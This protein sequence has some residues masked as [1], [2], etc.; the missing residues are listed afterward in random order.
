MF[1]TH[2]RFVMQ[3]RNILWRI[4]LLALLAYS[5]FSLVSV[6]LSLDETYETASLLRERLSLLQEENARL[7]A[8]AVQ[9]S[10]EMRL[11]EL[12]RERL[13][14]VLPGE[15]IFYFTQ[16]KINAIYIIHFYLKIWKM[17]LIEFWTQKMK[18]KKF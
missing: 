17:Q 3:S 18:K 6:R 7:K 16:K 10:D 12:A 15:K 9:D 11:Q 13:G 8:L 1:Y 4:V 5:V 2:E 14:L